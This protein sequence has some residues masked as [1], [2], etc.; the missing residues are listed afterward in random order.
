GDDVLRISRVYLADD[1]PVNYTISYI[2]IKLF[3]GIDKIDFGHT[4]LYEVLEQKY[5][6]RIMHATRTFEA[7]AVDQN[8]ANVLH[9]KKGDPVLLLCAVTYGEVNNVEVPIET[10]KCFYRSDK[11]KFYINQ[12]R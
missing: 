7:I 2:N 6:A 3:P 5:G 10:F 4:S 11:F 1:E 8:Q 12:V 9:M